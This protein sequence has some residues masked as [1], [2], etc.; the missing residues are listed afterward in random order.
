MRYVIGILEIEREKFYKTLREEIEILYLSNEEF[1]QN[2]VIH[3]MYIKEHYLNLC[4][5]DLIQYGYVVVN[6]IEFVV[7]KNLDK[8]I[9]KCLYE[10]YYKDLF[11]LMR[12]NHNNIMFAYQSIGNDKEK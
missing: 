2:S 11:K 1:M 5:I 8:A 7:E 10:E 4:L 3:Q 6:D 12:K 9:S